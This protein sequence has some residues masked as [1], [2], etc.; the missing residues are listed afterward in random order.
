MRRKKSIE[1]YEEGST[2]S[3]MSRSSDGIEFRDDSDDVDCFILHQILQLRKL[4]RLNQHYS[5]REHTCPI[6]SSKGNVRLEGG[7]SSGT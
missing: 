7:N 1:K 4:S 2:S 6:A 3:A 5:W